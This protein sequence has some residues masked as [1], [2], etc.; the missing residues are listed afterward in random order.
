M[1]YNSDYNIYG[2]KSCK[3][4]KTLAGFNK[5]FLFKKLFD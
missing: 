1:V 2:V 5:T 4:I 3:T